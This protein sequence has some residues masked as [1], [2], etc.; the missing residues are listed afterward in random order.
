MGIDVTSRIEKLGPI[1]G[2]RKFQFVWTMVFVI[3]FKQITG[4]SRTFGIIGDAV[5][6]GAIS[7]IGFFLVSIS[8]KRHVWIRRPD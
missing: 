7:G 8:A 4:E 3:V 2:S 5:I 6:G 1:L